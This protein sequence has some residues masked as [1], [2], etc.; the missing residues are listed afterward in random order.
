MSSQRI[1]KKARLCQSHRIRS[2]RIINSYAD[3]VKQQKVNKI[4]EE[5][6]KQQFLSRKSSSRNTELSP[7][8]TKIV[9]RLSFAERKVHTLHETEKSSSPKR[10]IVVI[11]KENLILWKSHRSGSRVVHSRRTIVSLC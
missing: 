4:V 10:K 9:K 6:I 8:S 2:S 7:Y 5:T 11:A 3:G 1:A